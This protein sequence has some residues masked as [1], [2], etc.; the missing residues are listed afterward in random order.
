MEETKEKVNH[1]TMLIYPTFFIHLMV[2]HTLS[3]HDKYCNI[4]KHSS[5]LSHRSEIMSPLARVFSQRVFSNSACSI[6]VRGKLL[7]S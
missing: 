1:I 7:K 6:S 2:H 5:C 4:F 3:K